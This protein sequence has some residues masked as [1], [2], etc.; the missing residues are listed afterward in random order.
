MRRDLL[1]Q[2][3]LPA[4]SR[5]ADEESWE[6]ERVSVGEELLVPSVD[7]GALGRSGSSEGS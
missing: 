2:G 6:A 1:A 7:E 4:V 5:D 3:T